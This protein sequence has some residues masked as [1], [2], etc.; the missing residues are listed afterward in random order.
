MTDLLSQNKL[1]LGGSI[2][3]SKTGQSK[4]EEGKKLQVEEVGVMS[5]GKP[6]WCVVLFYLFRIFFC[7]RPRRIWK[8]F[9]VRFRCHDLAMTMPIE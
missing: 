4:E 3:Y 2:Y 1:A 7:A 5:L 9:R 6:P 8:H